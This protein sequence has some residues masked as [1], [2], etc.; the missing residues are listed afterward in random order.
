V[1]CTLFLTK[2]K[3][4]LHN[5]PVT[6]TVHCASL[7]SI[8]TS[9]FSVEIVTEAKNCVVGHGGGTTL[10]ITFMSDREGLLPCSQEPAS[11]PCCK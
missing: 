11:G 8:S 4:M 1:I 7:L 2:K 10:D 6:N 5:S 9:F 3:E